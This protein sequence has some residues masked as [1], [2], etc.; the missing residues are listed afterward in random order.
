MLRPPSNAHFE[1]NTMNKK[2]FLTG[3]LGR[4]K[5]D[6]GAYIEFVTE[7]NAS[8]PEGIGFWGS[9]RLLMPVIEAISNAY[10]IKPE[11]LLAEL[12]VRTPKLVWVLFRHS[13]IHN[14]FLQ[15]GRYNET[16]ASWGLSFFGM[17][18]IIQDEVIGLDLRTLY[19]DLVSYLEKEIE[20]DSG[21]DDVE[22]IVGVIWESPEEKIINEFNLLA[23]KRLGTKYF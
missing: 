6:A 2:F 13:L 9:V 22:I 17:N 14:D 20:N 19:N 11:S 4:L 15:H 3:V 7:R 12:G 23:P 10:H 21:E 8:N 16:D 18:H 5:N 1:M